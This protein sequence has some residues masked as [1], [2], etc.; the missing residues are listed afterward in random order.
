ML[1]LHST[2]DAPAVEPLPAAVYTGLGRREE[3]VCVVHSSPRAEVTWTKD[4]Q[5]LDSTVET[6]Q[7]LSST[8]LY[9]TVL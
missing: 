5:P 3:V 2:L 9:C 7:V 6:S 1:T 8:V 4:G